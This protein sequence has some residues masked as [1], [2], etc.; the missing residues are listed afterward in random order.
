MAFK[1]TTPAGHEY[2]PT[3]NGKMYLSVFKHRGK[4]SQHKSIWSSAISPDMEYG[5]FCSSDESDWCDQNQNYWGV[6]E[7]GKKILGERGEYI[8]KF[9]RTSNQQDPWHGYPVSPKE[10][11]PSDTPPDSLVEQWVKDDVITKGFARKIYKLKI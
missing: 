4:S 10:N 8:C 6:L 11:G 2:G 7:K 3:V 1:Q 9:P 5:I